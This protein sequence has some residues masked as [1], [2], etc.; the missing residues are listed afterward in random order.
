M[1][2]ESLVEHYGYLAIFIGTF[3]EGETIVVLAGFLAHRGYLVLEWVIAWAFFGTYAGDQLFFYIGR[4]RGSGI[5]A[6]RPHWQLRSQRVFDL[7]NRHQVLVILGFR[8]LYGLRT[9]TPFLIGMS[10]VHPIRYLLLNGLGAIVWAIAIGVLGYLLGETI[11]LILQHV[12][13]YEM[14]IL[15]TITLAAAG[16]WLYRWLKEHR[17]IKSKQRDRDGC[18]D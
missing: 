2:L 8:F 13:H 9:V 1:S 7:L 6:K 17:Q 12:K 3:L 14:A 11:E 10:G 15:V 4:W 18:Q 5:L 16:Y